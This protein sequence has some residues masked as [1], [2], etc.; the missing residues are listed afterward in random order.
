MYVSCIKYWFWICASSLAARRK[1]KDTFYDKMIKIYWIKHTKSSYICE[2]WKLIKRFTW[3]VTF[4]QQLNN[5]LTNICLLI[6]KKWLKL[7]VKFL[8]MYC[9]GENRN[10]IGGENRLNLCKNTT[11]RWFCNRKVDVLVPNLVTVSAERAI[12]VA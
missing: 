7:F 2:K 12:E 10:R 11:N 9:L 4:M 5:I 6:M 8:K 3:N 1:K